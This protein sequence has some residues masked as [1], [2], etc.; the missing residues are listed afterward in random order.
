MKFKVLVWPCKR[1]QGHPKLTIFSH[2]PMVFLC[3]FGQ[4]PPIGS[5]DR[6]QTKFF[7][8]YCLC[9]VVTSWNLGQNHHSLIKS[10]NNPNVTIYEVWPESVI[11]FKRK[12]R[13]CWSN[14]ENFKFYSV[15]TLKIRWSQPKSSLILKPTQRYN[16]WMLARIRHLVG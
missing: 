10:S 7:F 14:F 16:I 6:V 1:G 3:K 9:S 13:F 8:I 15:L 5:G 2:L 12:T 11:W 4:N